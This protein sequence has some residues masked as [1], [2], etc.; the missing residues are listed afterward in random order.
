MANS[1]KSDDANAMVL[2][3]QNVLKRCKNANRSACRTGYVRSIY[4]VVSE[5]QS[6]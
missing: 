5:Y 4:I 2:S 1:E 3:I 6:L